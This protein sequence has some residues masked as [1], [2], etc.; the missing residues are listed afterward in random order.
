MAT[1]PRSELHDLADQLP[2]RDIIRALVRLKQLSHE[3]VEE[4][5]FVKEGTTLPPETDEMRRAQIEQ[6]ET[7]QIEHEKDFEEV[8][9]YAS[10]RLGIT[11]HKWFF[12]SYGGSEDG[13]IEYR[14]EW[15]DNGKTC[16]LTNPRLGQNEILIL[17]E[18]STSS[19]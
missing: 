9:A 12:R 13:G 16:R 15:P 6:M 19:D 17:E 10:R 14:A 2:E 4:I 1:D 3:T 18:L 11:L 7:M 5:T 8:R